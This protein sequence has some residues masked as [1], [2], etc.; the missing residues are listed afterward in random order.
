MTHPRL[1]RSADPRPKSGIVH[2]G[3]GAFFRAFCAPMISD[4]MAFSG[5]DWGVVGVS[6]RSPGVRDALQDQGWAYTALSIAAESETP[7]VVDVLN[8]VLVA[9]E[10]PAKVLHAMMDT[11]V[12]IVSLTVTE[13]GYCHIPATGKLDLANADIV[14]DLASPDPRSAIGFI[15]RALAGRMRAGTAAFTVLSCDNLPQ[16]GQLLRGLVL[17]FAGLVDPEL[18]NWIEDQ[19][20]FPCTMVD[21]ITP[22]TTAEDIVRI[23]QMTGWYDAAPVVHEPFAQW[24]IED[25]FVEDARPNLAAAGVQFVADVSTHEE[26]KLRMLN[27]THSALA[28][29]GYLA[30]YDT[31][32]QTVADPILDRFVRDLWDEIIPSVVA[33]EGIDLDVYATSLLARYNNAG[34]HHRTWQIAMDGSQ[35]LPQRMLGTV[36]DALNDGRDTPLLCLAIA[37]WMYYAGGVDEA[38]HAIDVRDPLLSE[39]RARTRGIEGPIATVAALLD[40]PTVF[41]EDLAQQLKTPLTAAAKDVW[42]HGVRAAIEQAN[43]LNAHKSERL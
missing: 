10:N 36:R 34:I 21:R 24:V 1:N 41:P 7:R 8:D 9:P 17:E 16:N 26:M 39:L 13:K 29:T 18:R 6:L 42:A 11:D 40:M 20:R 33:P 38:G 14:H 19:A 5:G 27:G 37:A 25:A 32:S 35:K 43:A 22:A 31:I 2:L 28:Y 15:V 30:G 12:R 23:T 3:L 4:A